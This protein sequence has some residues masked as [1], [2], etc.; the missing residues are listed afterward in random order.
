MTLI[1]NTV[2]SRTKVGQ[3]IKHFVLP[4]KFHQFSGFVYLT[5]VNFI[6]AVSAG[7][8]SRAN[9]LNTAA[10]GSIVTNWVI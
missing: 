3:A 4:C 5:I 2:L 10:A 9:P 8:E 7:H 6:T 1:L